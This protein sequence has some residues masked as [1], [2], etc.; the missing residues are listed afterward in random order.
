VGSDWGEYAMIQVRQMTEEDVELVYQVFT[1]H[2]IGKSRDYILKCWEEN[3]SGGRI[4]LLAF[5]NGQFAGSLHL[6]AKS[7][8]PYFSDN[9]IPEINDFNVIAPLR[10]LGIG[11]A[12]ME[13]AEK[14]ALEK[15]GIVGIGVG[16]YQSYG[17]AQRMYA[18]RGY[19]PDGRGLMYK[20]Q[21][22][23]P[24]SQVCVDDDLVLYFTKGC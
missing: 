4:T 15:Y 19:I 11:N 24:G 18:K 12:L 5:H 20:G 9:N 13:A 21:S 23:T 17:S 16:M 2:H 7:D 14:I 6:L 1:E 3:H 22:V 10:K 8:Y